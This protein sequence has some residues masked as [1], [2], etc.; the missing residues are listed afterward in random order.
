MEDKIGRFVDEVREALF[1]EAYDWV[2]E[3]C[4]KKLK[5][6]PA[7]MRIHAYL[8]IGA[9]KNKQYIRAINKASRA[10]DTAESEDIYTIMLRSL[11]NV[12][13]KKLKESNVDI[14]ESIKQEANEQLKG[15]DNLILDNIENIKSLIKED[16]DLFGEIFE[17]IQQI[18]SNAEDKKEL[19]LN[20]LLEDKLAFAAEHFASFFGPTQSDAEVKAAMAFIFKNYEESVKLC[21]EVLEKEKNSKIEALKAKNMYE[22][23][24]FDDAFKYFKKAIDAGLNKKELLFYAANCLIE[25]D[26]KK[27]SIQ[28]IDKALEIDPKDINL[29]TNKGAALSELKRYKEALNCF[30]RALEL[31]PS[32]KTLLANKGIVLKNLS[33]YDEAINCF[34][35]HVELTKDINILLG[36]AEELSLEGDFKRAKKC[37]SMIIEKE[38][39]EFALLGIVD[40]L[41]EL[42]DEKKAIEYCNKLIDISKNEGVLEDTLYCLKEL[43]SDTGKCINKLITINPNNKIALNEKGIILAK[44]NKYAQALNFLNRGEDSDCNTNYEFLINKAICLEK[45]RQLKE[46]EKY[47]KKALSINK[48]EEA[49]KGI[50]RCK[51]ALRHKEGLLKKKQSLELLELTKDYAKIISICNSILRECPN[52][53]FCLEKKAYCLLEINKKEEAIKY[54]N[55]LIET[56]NDEGV[57]IK[58]LRLYKNLNLDATKCYNKLLQININNK[59]ANAEKGIYLTNAKEYNEAVNCF[60]K[61]KTDIDDL[62][63]LRCRALSSQMTKNYSNAV[64]Y[65]KKFFDKGESF[66]NS[67]LFDYFY[68]SL[69]I[70]SYDLATNV[71][72]KLLQNLSLDSI[73]NCIAYLDDK[74]K[75]HIKSFILEYL[76]LKAEADKDYNKSIE[77]YTRLLSYEDDKRIIRRIKEILNQN[78]RV[79]TVNAK[80]KLGFHDFKELVICDSNILV[81]KVFYDLNGIMNILGDERCEKAFCKF[82]QI[83]SNGYIALTDTI[84]RQISFVWPSLFDAYLGGIGVEDK[85]K[86]KEQIE[87]RIN[88][89]KRYY[90][91]SKIITSPLLTTQEDL[92]KIEDFYR[93]F[94]D[95]L[96]AITERKIS[97]LNEV[98]KVKKLMARNNGVLPERSDMYILAQALKLN[99]SC[100][101]GINR[102]AIFSDD[103]DFC[104]F[105]DEI[106]K[107][108]NI[109]IY[110]L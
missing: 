70:K 17:D 14:H 49:L 40:C 97:G 20:Y 94:P 72:A 99:N 88:K 79:I 110:P 66:G 45:T 81:F 54:Y 90:G 75:N 5:K 105:S 12:S 39:N 77:Y 38:E 109:K 96:K 86:I 62:E 36:F 43:E 8:C 30:N 68:C 44:N 32:D 9:Y 41:I 2:D 18:K 95:R 74:E 27:E 31:D 33:L 89:Y 78:E 71:L 107:E 108:L 56:T 102:I 16:P 76:A 21:D 59:H 106:E 92:N 19:G 26:R 87:N 13:L 100:I 57:L 104:E 46:G 52:D 6:F 35:K 83:T 11:I 61:V 1:D 84:M 24:K 10:L 55:L 73:F 51:K 85:E 98:D 67:L 25:L 37:Y 47:Y 60:A 4:R 22:L 64:E 34:N 58:I 103:S 42:N 101:N 65:Y 3:Q 91:I 23:E 50:K 48:S 69:K 63:Y 15:I 29:L 7:D 80:S 53:Y 28:Y 93:K 82:Q